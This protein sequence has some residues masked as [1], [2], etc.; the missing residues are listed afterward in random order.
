MATDPPYSENHLRFRYSISRIFVTHQPITVKVLHKRLWKKWKK[1]ATWMCTML[2]WNT[3]NILQAIPSPSPPHE[4][5][6]E[7]TTG[8]PIG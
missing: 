2:G 5:R 1:S 6:P 4:T 7:S 3:S 8:G